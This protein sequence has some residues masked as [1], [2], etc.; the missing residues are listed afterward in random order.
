MGRLGDAYTLGSL[1]C[2]WGAIEFFV[3][4]MMEDYA[5]IPQGIFTLHEQGFL[6]EKQV[7]FSPKGQFAGEFVFSGKREYR[8]LEDKITFLLKK[9]GKIKETNRGSGLWQKF[10]KMKEKRDAIVHPR[11]NSRV[12]LLPSDAEAAIAIA[13]EV[14]ELLAWEIWRKKIAW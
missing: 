12:S 1:L 10:E 8:K 6:E 9:F 5:S 4:G 2:A 14:I 11:R 3:N 13:K 7:I